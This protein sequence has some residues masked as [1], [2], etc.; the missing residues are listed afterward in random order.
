MN[1]RIKE[2]RKKLGLTL[3]KFGEKVGVGKTAISRIENGSNGVT[4]QMFKSIC[5]EFDVNEEWLRTGE[6]EMFKLKTRD[7]E[8][9]E[10]LADIQVAGDEDFRHRFI[11]VLTKLD[12]K[13]WEVLEKFVNMMIDE[14]KD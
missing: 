9:A 7:E 3:E 8:I 11:N 12:A 13:E 5:R 2:L 14:K 1:E 10:M 6:G 4:D